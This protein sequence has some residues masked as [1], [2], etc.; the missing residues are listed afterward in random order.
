MS[1]ATH[2]VGEAWLQGYPYH[3]ST[4]EQGWGYWQQNTWAGHGTSY[5]S[6]SRVG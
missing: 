2:E 4:N 5:A 1:D 6:D 3:Q